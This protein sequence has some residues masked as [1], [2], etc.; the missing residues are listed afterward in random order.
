M[1]DTDYSTEVGDVVD[2]LNAVYEN[3]QANKKN[4]ISGDY[5]S[6]NASYPTVKAVKAAYGTKV[7]S[8]SSTV[9]DSNIPSEKLVK[10]ALDG[11]SGTGHNHATGDITNSATLANIGSNLTN[12]GAINSA[13][14]DVIGALKGTKFIEIENKPATASDSTMGK[15]YVV[16]ESGKVNVYYTKQTGTGSSATYSW[17]KLDANILDDLEDATQS[18]HGLMSA[19]DKLKLDKSEIN[20]MVCTLYQNFLGTALTFSSNS[21]NS[22]I[23]NNSLLVVDTT[24]LSSS[25]ISTLKTNYGGYGVII[26]P[27]VSLPLTLGAYSANNGEFVELTVKDFVNLEKVLVQPVLNSQEVSE[28][29]AI[30]FNMPSETNVVNEIKVFA[31]QLA[32]AINPSSS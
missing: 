17:Q 3:K 1:T 23:S 29:I 14:N 27:E 2:A 11:K 26:E 15:L 13:L 31:G 8:W 7:T 18:V 32:E 30:V 10:D 9:S 4:D 21:F 16:T 28:N 22:G 12:Q 24:G 25:D 6:D 20:R 5:S 19:T